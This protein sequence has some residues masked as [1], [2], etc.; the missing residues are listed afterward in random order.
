MTIRLTRT[1]QTLAR[2]VMRAW[3]IQ[4]VP[5]LLHTTRILCQRERNP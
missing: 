1:D 3:P 5:S 2:P 4:Q